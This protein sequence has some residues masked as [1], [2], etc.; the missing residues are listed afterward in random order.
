MDSINA[1]WV[2]NIEII[3][4]QNQDWVFQVLTPLSLLFFILPQGLIAHL[5]E[6]SNELSCQDTSN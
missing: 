3:T 2:Y 6:K 4:G 1:K 5:Q